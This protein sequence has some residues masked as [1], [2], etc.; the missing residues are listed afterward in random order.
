[1]AAV[2]FDG[3]DYGWEVPVNV[4]RWDSPGLGSHISWV[5]NVAH[6]NIIRERI[7][8]MTGRPTVTIN[9]VKY[10]RLRRDEW[11]PAELLRD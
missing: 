6:L 10:R 5:L 7:F 9:G 1:M 8:S 11:V 4:F 3:V 2:G